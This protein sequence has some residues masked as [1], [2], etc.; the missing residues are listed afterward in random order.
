VTSLPRVSVLSN[1]FVQFEFFHNVVGL[2]LGGEKDN[3]RVLA[4]QPASTLK[5][6]DANQLTAFQSCEAVLRQCWKAAPVI[7]V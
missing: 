3:L 7:Q 6:Q 2:K 4:N 1:V 5:W